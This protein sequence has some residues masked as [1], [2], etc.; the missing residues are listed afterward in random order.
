[1]NIKNL[2]R[3]FLISL[4]AINTNTKANTYTIKHKNQTIYQPAMAA[5][6]LMNIFYQNCQASSLPKYNFLIEGEIKGFK[7]EFNPD[8][9]GKVSAVENL[10]DARKLKYLNCSNGNNSIC[11]TP[12]SYLWGGKGIYLSETN[13]FDIF[14]NNPIVEL[15]AKHPGLDCSGFINLSFILAGLKV[16]QNFPFQNSPDE[17]SAKEFMKPLSC[18]REIKI[19]KGEKIKAGDIIAWNKHIVMID[20]LTS[21]PFGIQ[22]FKSPEQ[23]DLRNLD[24]SRAKMLVLNSKG[25]NDPESSLNF[26]I[27]KYNSYLSRILKQANLQTTGVGPGII[28]NELGQLTFTNPEDVMDLIQTACLAKF[29]INLPSR[30]IKVVRHKLA[31][32]SYTQND[33]KNCTIPEIERPKF[34]GDELK[35]L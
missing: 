22:S 1:M 13:Q 30:K 7:A 2:F 21:D 19:E 27:S 28:K 18:F 35:C 4:F 33:L 5:N 16:D 17:I 24:P 3:L 34:I 26:E 25:A 32:P 20:Q 15:K 8:T 6:R 31:E 12:P 11:S 10:S 14:H 23:C 29:N 9:N